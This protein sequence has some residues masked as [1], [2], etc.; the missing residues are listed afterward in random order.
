MTTWGAAKAFAEG[1]ALYQ[2]KIKRESPNSKIV[3]HGKARNAFGSLEWGACTHFDQL[4]A[5]PQLVMRLAMSYVEI[6]SA[7]Y[8]GEKARKRRLRAEAGDV[9]DAQNR[10]LRQ[11]QERDQVITSLK[12]QL[13][14]AQES[15]DTVQSALTMAES[16]LE[17]KKNS[18]PKRRRKA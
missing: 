16:Q 18:K 9:T 7:Y 15:L 14:E 5:L 3:R 11:L 1:R 10:Y 8:K 4:V 12:A 2:A 17:Q 13:S 6:E